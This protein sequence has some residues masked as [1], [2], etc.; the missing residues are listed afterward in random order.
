MAIYRA[1][2]KLREF[3]QRFN[4]YHYQQ[5]MAL[6]VA[7]TRK[8]AF[9]QLQLTSDT[10]LLEV[11]VGNGSS[12]E[13]YPKDLQL[14]GI[15]FSATLI[16]EARTRAIKQRL[17]RAQFYVMNAQNLRAFADDSFDAVVSLSL[18]SVVPDPHQAFSEMIRVC[19]PGG[20]IAV[21]SHFMHS[22]GWQKYADQWMSPMVEAVLGYQV[23]MSE[24]LIYSRK[25]IKVL[26]RE[27]HPLGPY[28]MN[29][30][31]VVEKT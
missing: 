10:K 24:D 12:L 4:V 30:L 20:K 9:E 23:R 19:R 22:Q 29:T 21:T 1:K 15:D 3:L 5:Y 14:T 11:G 28:V 6:V 13:F 16:K 17:T 18:L 8:R 2:R 27:E 26:L 31:F 25:D 7:P